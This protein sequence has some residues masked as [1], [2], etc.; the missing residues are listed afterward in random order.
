M[1]FFK[2]LFQKKS[3][4]EHLSETKKVKLHGIIF[5]IRKIG[6]LS[7]MDGSASLLTNYDVYSLDK[8]E[9]SPKGEVE[10]KR[11]MKK[12]QD[13]WRDVIMAGV[14]TPALTRKPDKEPDKIPVDEVLGDFEL[15]SDLYSAIMLYTYGKKKMIQSLSQGSV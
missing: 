14:V 1:G 10:L 15:S 4:R 5:H 8:G 2:N 7:Y 9:L 11:H 13:H 3:L 6:P 12:M